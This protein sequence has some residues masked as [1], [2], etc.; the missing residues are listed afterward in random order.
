M[1]SNNILD[2]EVTNSQPQQPTERPVAITVIC[3]LGFIGA[4]ITIPLIFS[5][6]ASSIGGWYPP[7]LAFSAAVGLACMIGM[8]KMKKWGAYTYTGIVGLNQLV[9]LAMGVWNIVS[10]LVPAIVVAIALTHVKK[11]D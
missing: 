5:N 8:W 6:A 3:V 10:L 7:Y 11:M 2:K 4:A 9:L 1:E